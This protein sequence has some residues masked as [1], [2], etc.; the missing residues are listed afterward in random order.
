MAAEPLEQL[1]VVKDLIEML[2]TASVMKVAL[3]RLRRPPFPPRSAWASSWEA[4]A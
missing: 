1:L 4:T 2:T 3:P